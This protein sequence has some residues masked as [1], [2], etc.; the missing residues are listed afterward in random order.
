MAGDEHMDEILLLGE[1]GKL[2]G[3]EVGAAV[4]DQELEF[5]WQQSAERG[6]DLLGGDLGADGKEG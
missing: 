6:D 2:V 4:G 1:L 5:V 3:G